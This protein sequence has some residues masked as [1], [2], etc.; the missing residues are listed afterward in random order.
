MTVESMENHQFRVVVNQEEQYSLW[1]KS[2]PNALGWE[3]TGFE[4]TTSECLLHIRRIWTDMRPLS[5]R[6]SCRA[7]IAANRQHTQ[8][9][10]LTQR[11]RHA[12]CLAA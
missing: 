10:Q 6:E 7:G 5:L 1:P 12:V 8:H 2:K 11:A 4:G 9:T 3:D